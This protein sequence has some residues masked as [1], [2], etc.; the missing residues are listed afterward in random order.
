MKIGITFSKSPKF[1]YEDYNVE[2]NVI[3]KDLEH[4]R[5]YI[6][7]N[8]LQETLAYIKKSKNYNCKISLLRDPDMRKCDGNVT[9]FS[10]GILLRKEIGEKE[11]RIY[12]FNSK[13]L[14]EGSIGNK[15]YFISSICLN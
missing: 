13:L 12:D 1:R 8:N 3:Y 4:L 7:D 6:I 9:S 11:F 15:R 2:G 14:A 5:E 10:R